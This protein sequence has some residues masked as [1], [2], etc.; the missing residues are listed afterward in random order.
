MRLRVGSKAGVWPKDELSLRGRGGDGRGVM[1]EADVAQDGLDGGW[2]GEEGEHARG[3]AT[4]G[5]E[6][7]QYILDAGEELRHRTLRNGFGEGLF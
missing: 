2:V 3:S 7:R 1:K 5:T 6:R 4:S